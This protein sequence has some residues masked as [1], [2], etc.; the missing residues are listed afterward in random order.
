[1]DFLAKPIHAAALWAAIE[2]VVAPGPPARPTARLIAADVLLAA[3]D[4]SPVILDKI[5]QGLRAQLPRDLAVIERTFEAGDAL[6]LREAAHR[7]SGMLAAFSTLAGGLASELEDRASRG[8]FQEAGALIARLRAI[9]PEL[10][11]AVEGLSIEAL[12]ADAHG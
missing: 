8:E 6:R 12:E 5:C 4:G 3:C 10:L 1:D 7:V 9:A 11:R 2:G